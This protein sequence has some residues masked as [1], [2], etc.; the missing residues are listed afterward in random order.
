MWGLRVGFITFGTK[1]GS[2]ATYAA[3]EQKA[4]GAIRGAI[5][6]VTMPGQSVVLKALQQADFE[7]QVAAKV[8]ILEERVRVVSE[9]AANPEYA[10]CWDVYPFNAGYFMCLRL[11]GADAETV[12]V[13]LLDEH[14]IG[15][16]ALGATDLRVAFSCVEA[17]D[18][19][20]LFDR[21]AQSIRAVASA[22]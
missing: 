13:H 4:G 10:D 18:I 21:V 11:K 6:N 3:L 12:R 16:V 14:Q 5:S 22:S 19:V 20:D 8:A 2:S 1:N 9:A 17:G 7:D 15:A